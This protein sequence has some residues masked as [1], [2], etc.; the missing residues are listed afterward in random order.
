[1]AWRNGRL[2]TLGLALIGLSVSSLGAELYRYQDER[3]VTVVDWAIPAA[4]V[5]N[6]YEVLNEMGQFV[7]VVQPAK[8]ETE[9][10]QEAARTRLQIA[11]A[12]AEA[13]QLERDTFLLRR[14]SGF[15]T[16]RL[17]A[18]DHCASWRFVLPSSIASAR[19]CLTNSR[20]R[21]PPL[22]AG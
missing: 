15:M 6:G 14:Y 1:M 5:T 18:T 11:E 4:Y 8:T 17:P 3:G 16:L 10:E 9:L 13:A 20:R 7:R 21:R 2:A 22:Q 12:A 19:H